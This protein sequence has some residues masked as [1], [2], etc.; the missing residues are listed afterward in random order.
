LGKK[1]R[2]QAAAPELLSSATAAFMNHRE[3]FFTI[4]PGDEKTSLATA[5]WRCLCIC[6]TRSKA[7]AH[8]LGHFTARV[9]YPDNINIHNNTYLRVRMECLVVKDAVFSAPLLLFT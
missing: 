7:G 5:L 4:M 1:K 8:F 9:Y 2:L 3:S 6:V